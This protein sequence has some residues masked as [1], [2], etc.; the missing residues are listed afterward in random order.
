[1]PHIS[2]HPDTLAEGL[3]RCRVSSLVSE[4]VSDWRPDGGGVTLL[5]G[6]A[7]IQKPAVIP[8]DSIGGTLLTKQHSSGRRE[9]SEG[10]MKTA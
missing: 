3:Q 1:M 10:V 5:L 4:V 8:I 6:I 2:D 7:Q 9:E